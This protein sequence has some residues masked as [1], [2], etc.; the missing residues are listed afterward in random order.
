MKNVVKCLIII[1]FIFMPT[2]VN[3][4][5]VCN[6]GTV[7]PTCTDCH[8]GCCS[9]HGG[10]TDNPNH[11]GNSS[12]YYGA[13]QNF[14]YSAQEST[15]AP[16][17][18]PVVEPEPQQPTESTSSA[19]ESDV[20][21]EDELEDDTN[22]EETYGITNTKTSVKSNNDEGVADFLGGL[23]VLGAIGAAIYKAKANKG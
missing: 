11:G 5:I 2:M 23:A 8:R 4:N 3:A 7:S 15:P 19:E 18:A 17:P 22:E 1:S 9:R 13:T 20:K 16:A 6:D 12:N 14:N 10:C 21:I